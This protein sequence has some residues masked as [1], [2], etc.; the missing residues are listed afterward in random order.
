MQIIFILPNEFLGRH[1]TRYQD[2]H[3]D[4]HQ[5]SLAR[6]RQ[7]SPRCRGLIVTFEGAR[8]WDA[9]RLACCGC[10]EGRLD[11]TD[12]LGGGRTNGGRGRLFGNA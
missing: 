9:A 5:Q 7:Q 11:V 3:W 6:G 8:S 4:R 2:R 10:L 1:R 12:A